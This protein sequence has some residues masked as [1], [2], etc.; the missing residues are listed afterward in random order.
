M[1]T[2]GNLEQESTSTIQIENSN[3]NT[4]SSA[5]E[6]LLSS[7][8]VTNTSHA[9]P[10]SNDSDLASEKVS[11]KASDKAASSKG[12]NS[13]KMFSR[14]KDVIIKTLLRKCR[15]F[16]LKDFNSKT[17]YLKTAKRKFG[18]S[19]Y[20]TLLEDYINS[21][22]QVDC[23]EKML[24]FLGVFLYQQDLEDNLDLF[25]SPNYSPKEI[26]KLIT[27]VHEILYKYSHQKFYYFSKNKEFK[28]LFTYFEKLGTDEVKADREYAIGLDIIRGQL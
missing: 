17:N 25:T 11:E 20:K 22:F 6:D 23:S 2:Q 24:I 28:F 15:K 19:I 1:L 5:G 26:K 10:T 16:F 27:T 18:S 21:V 4:L 14:R 3:S 9:L 8:P 7:Q 12:K 13:N